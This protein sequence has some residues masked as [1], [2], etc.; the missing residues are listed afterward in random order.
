MFFSR[1]F[2]VSV[3]LQL[4]VHAVAPRRKHRRI[5]GQ[6]HITQFFKPV[7]Q[8]SKKKIALPLLPCDIWQHI[9]SFCDV[10]LPALLCVSKEMREL[11]VASEELDCTVLATRYP[12]FSTDKQLAFAVT[13]AQVK[14]LTLPMPNAAYLQHIIDY[15]SRNETIEMLVFKKNNASSIMT[16]DE[17][18]CILTLFK[19]TQITSHYTG[20]I[21]VPAD[22]AKFFM[23]QK[24]KQACPH[25]RIIEE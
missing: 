20:T 11:V 7:L 23:V 1:I 17:A 13:C 24:M 14:K 22:G 5:V 15:L 3:F 10:S 18:G 16:P 25:A 19:D 8:K 12:A 2:M 4:S 21:V 6:R 9:I